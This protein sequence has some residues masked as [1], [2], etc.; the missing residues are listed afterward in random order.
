MK[1]AAIS[2]S[3][4]NSSTNHLSLAQL[5]SAISKHKHVNEAAVVGVHDKIKGQALCC[6]VTL[7]DSVTKYPDL[8]TEIRY[9]VK[10]RVGAF[11]VPKLIV[12]TPG[13]CKTRSG[14]IM[15][16]MLQKVCTYTSFPSCHNDR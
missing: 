6:F 5:E 8:G 16:R 15:R 12:I 3:N 1:L 2:V 11:A 14:K 9:E 7:K 4:N 10:T 13:L